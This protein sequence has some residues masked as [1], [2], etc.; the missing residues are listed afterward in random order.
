M[1]K[2]TPVWNHN[3]TRFCESNPGI[4]RLEQVVVVGD[5]N[6]GDTVGLGMFLWR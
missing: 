6:R 3:G 5:L 4:Y 1:E 2:R